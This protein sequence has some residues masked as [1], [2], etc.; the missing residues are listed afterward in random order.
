MAPSG[1]FFLPAELRAEALDSRLGAPA[2][3]GDGSV[4]VDVR[5]GAFR[6]PSGSFLRFAR[7]RTDPVAVSRGTVRRIFQKHSP[8]TSCVTLSLSTPMLH[9]VG[10]SRSL[11]SASAGI[12]VLPEFRPNK[13]LNLLRW[14]LGCSPFCNSKVA[15]MPT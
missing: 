15:A 3:K 13:D 2:G 8:G 14:R 9:F 5:A 12:S 6:R 1:V 7:R 11:S 4:E 10:T